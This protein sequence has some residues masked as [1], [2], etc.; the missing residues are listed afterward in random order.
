MRIDTGDV[1]VVSTGV[2]GFPSIFL[3][4]LGVRQ[5]PQIFAGF[6]YSFVKFVVIHDLQWCSSMLFFS[7]EI[8]G[9][10]TVGARIIPSGMSTRTAPSVHCSTTGGWLAQALVPTDVFDGSLCFAFDPG[11]PSPGQPAN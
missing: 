8:R 7:M 4:P 3:V 9:R 5:C 10:P 1:F 11:Q 2:R 6:K